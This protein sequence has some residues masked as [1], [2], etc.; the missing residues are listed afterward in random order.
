MINF[1]GYLETLSAGMGPWSLMVRM[2][3]I[4][5]ICL[6]V[7]L[8]GVAPRR[9]PAQTTAGNK[10]DA[11]RFGV[12]VE[13]PSGPA[14]DSVPAWARQGLIYFARWDG[15]RL[16][17]V[18]GIL[19]GWPHFWPPNPDILYATSNWYDPR[20]IQLLHQAGVNMIW[21]TFSNGFSNET[22]KLSLPIT[23]RSA[24]ARAFT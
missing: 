12:P 16:E 8:F 23:S 13:W 5:R 2:G 20:T 15:G 1:Y 18:K 17:S 19:S 22:E 4:T 9:L 3:F 11:S 14:K 10:A 21:V 24:I 7:L 6:L